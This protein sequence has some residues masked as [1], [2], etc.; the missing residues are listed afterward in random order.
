MTKTS[1]T[2]YI[3]CT[4]TYYLGINTGIQRVVRNIVKRAVALSDTEGQKFVPVVSNFGHFWRSPRFNALQLASQNMSTVMHGGT[5]A[6]VWLS[7]HEKKAIQKSKK[8]SPWLAYAYFIS[9]IRRLIR[10]GGYALLQTPFVVGL[11]TGSI[12]RIKPK[13]GD[14]LLMPD[15]F[16]AYDVV[17]P[18]NKRRNQKLIVAP[19][20]H[21]LIPV[22]H[23]QYCDKH[24]VK[25]FKRLLPQI[26]AHSSA[27]V[28]ISHS[29][30]N[31]LLAFFK[32]HGMQREAALPTAIW[33]SG[34]DIANEPD[35]GIE[36]LPIRS[37]I[38]TMDFATDTFLMVGTIEPRKGYD[39]AF[40]VFTRMWDAGR[41][42]RLVI[43]GRVGWMCEDLVEAMTNSP[44]VNRHLF[45]YT[46]ANDNEL[47]F[48]YEHSTALIFASRAE[49]F[50]L[51][52]VEAMQKGL[53]VIASDIP[54]FKEIGGDSARYFVTQDLDDLERTIV[55]FVEN[56][57][58]QHDA[59]EW[60]DWD[61]AT[62]R[63]LDTCSK[64]ADEASPTET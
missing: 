12:R 18:L 4:A 40:V 25:T 21:D 48:F 37:D 20:I 59:L 9:A 58:E 41:T 63:L 57:P 61:Q 13:S 14:F 7:A 2:I 19:M 60:H 1:R 34:A 16:W 15:A 27:F 30:R 44:Y 42:E 29:T 55:E 5:K 39:D 46:N 22:T 10:Y 54:V 64:L 56:K 43:V 47:D 38:Q 32:D 31:S 52:L 45:I 17:T 35:S 8:F 62:R 36:E 51:P 11:L 50:G 53:D 24:F 23:P 6:S 49:G 3:D 28:C 33:Y 26:C